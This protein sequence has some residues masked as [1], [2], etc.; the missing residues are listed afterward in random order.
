MT[1]IKRI[2]IVV[3]RKKKNAL[4]V[5]YPVV[6]NI[7]DVVNFFPK[8]VDEIQKRTNLVIDQTKKE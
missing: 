6:K 3:N 7:Q 5:F 8:T 2:G 4:S 1:R